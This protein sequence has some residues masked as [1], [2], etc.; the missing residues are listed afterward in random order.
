MKL[1]VCAIGRT[2]PSIENEFVNCRLGGSPSSILLAISGNPAAP[3]VIIPGKKRLSE[4]T[5]S[6]DEL[7]APLMNAPLFP[8]IKSRARGLRGSISPFHEP[9]AHGP[10]MGKTIVITQGRWWCVY[11]HS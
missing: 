6:S 4:P 9:A 7:L 3:L 10:R 1:L 2:H 5:K 11:F 8:P